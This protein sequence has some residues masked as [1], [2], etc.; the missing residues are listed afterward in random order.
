M[1]PIDHNFVAEGPL[2]T[3]IEAAQDIVSQSC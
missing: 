1:L 3:V 2:A